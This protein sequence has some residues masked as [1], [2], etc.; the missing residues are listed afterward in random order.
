M[1]LPVGGISPAILQGNAAFTPKGGCPLKLFLVVGRDTQR[2]HDVA[3]T[4][5]GG[6]PLKLSDVDL[7]RKCTR[8]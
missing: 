4:H 2:I 7:M 5:K 8:W 6:C 3:F 1:K